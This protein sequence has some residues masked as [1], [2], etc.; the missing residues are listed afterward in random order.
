M[1][2]QIFK[3]GL[4]RSR[5]IRKKILDAST[6]CGFGRSRAGRGEAVT[7]FHAELSGTRLPACFYLP[8]LSFTVCS[9]TSHTRF[10][11]STLLGITRRRHRYHRRTESTSRHCSVFLCSFIS[12]PLP[13]LV[14]LRAYAFVYHPLHFLPS[15]VSKI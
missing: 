6:D 12:C 11:F 5:K 3:R 4:G 1:K 2:T 9:Y 10:M 8:L 13:L 7:A 15:Q 14:S